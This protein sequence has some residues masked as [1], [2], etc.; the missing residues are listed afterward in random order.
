MDPLLTSIICLVATAFVVDKI[1]VIVYMNNCRERRIGPVFLN[2]DI[3][4]QGDSME[5]PCYNSVLF[6][7]VVAFP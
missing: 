4:A 7:A 6:V 1:Q 2:Q 3:R 5:L